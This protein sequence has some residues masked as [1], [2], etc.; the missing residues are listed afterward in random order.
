MRRSGRRFSGGPAK[1]GWEGRG[2]NKTPPVEEL[3]E[4]IRGGIANCACKGILNV[5]RSGAIALGKEASGQPSQ[6]CAFFTLID[7]ETIDWFCFSVFSRAQIETQA[8]NS[9]RKATGRNAAINLL[10]GKRDI[11]IMQIIHIRFAFS[12][13]AQGDLSHYRTLPCAIQ[14]PLPCRKA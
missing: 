1:E 12:D 13:A 9:H 10:S 4:G 7:E 11:N 14:S 3:T 2:S 8:T 5:T 6:S